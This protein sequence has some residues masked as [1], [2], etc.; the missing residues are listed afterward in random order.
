MPVKAFTLSFGASTLEWVLSFYMHIIPRLFQYINIFR[1]I[2]RYI[3]NINRINMLFKMIFLRH[4]IL[5]PYAFLDKHKADYAFD[6]V[7][8]L[9]ECVDGYNGKR[10]K[11]A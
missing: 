3:E 6:D 10:C 1:G 8:G 7:S 9:H 2:K 4:N 5:H 11:A